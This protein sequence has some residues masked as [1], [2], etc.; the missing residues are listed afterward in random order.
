M[1]LS[2]LWVIHKSPAAAG[3]GP[4]G[5]RNAS[6]DKGGYKGGNVGV[7][8]KAHRGKVVN[9]LCGHEEKFDRQKGLITAYDV[10]A[11]LVGACPP[12]GIDPR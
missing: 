11:I 6:G 5:Q 12:V 2:A 4:E 10:H 3:G 1:G 9:R 8:G 7:L